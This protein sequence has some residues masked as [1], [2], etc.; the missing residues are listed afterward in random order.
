MTCPSE[1]RGFV[2]LFEVNSV[3]VRGGWTAFQAFLATVGRLVSLTF[4]VCRWEE[5]AEHRLVGVSVTDV[6]ALERCHFLLIRSLV[7]CVSN[8][9]KHFLRKKKCCALNLPQEPHVPS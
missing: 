9:E 1:L 6:P 2:F 7:A 8:Q 4:V 5:R 3:K